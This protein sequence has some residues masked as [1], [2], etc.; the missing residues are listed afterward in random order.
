[1]RVRGSHGFGFTKEAEYSNLK[2]EI[3]MDKEQ[4]KEGQKEKFCC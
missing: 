2:A 1:M 3:P 4:E